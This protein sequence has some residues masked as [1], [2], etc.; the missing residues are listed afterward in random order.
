M[1]RKHVT[2]MLLWVVLWATAQT[3]MSSTSDVDDNGNMTLVTIHQNNNDL[4]SVEVFATEEQAT[5]YIE[6]S[7]QEQKKRMKL[8]HLED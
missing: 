2:I 1:V 4:L 8:V 5:K 7:T 3:K 6:S